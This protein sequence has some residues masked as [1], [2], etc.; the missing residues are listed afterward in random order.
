MSEDRQKGSNSCGANLVYRLLLNWLDE[1]A[2]PAHARY[3]DFQTF[4]PTYTQPS[5][6]TR[7]VMARVL[8]PQEY[9][10]S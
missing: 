7:A 1:M 3:C 9:S 6:A 4:W 2:G 8:T 10:N 5:P